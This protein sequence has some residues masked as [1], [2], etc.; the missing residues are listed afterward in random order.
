[1]ALE[2]RARRFNLGGVSSHQGFY[3]VGPVSLDQCSSFLEPLARKP[4]VEASIA[5]VAEGESQAHPLPRQLDRIER[6]AG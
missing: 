3:V 1:L 6:V 2:I 4:Q 5:A